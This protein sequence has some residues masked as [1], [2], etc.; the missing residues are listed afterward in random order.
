MCEFG[1]V[2]SASKCVVCSDK[3]SC[4]SCLTANQILQ[5]GSIFFV[6]LLLISSLLLC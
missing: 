6:I 3:M 5:R 1:A 4:V 2:M